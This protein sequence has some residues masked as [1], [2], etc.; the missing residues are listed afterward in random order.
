MLEIKFN[1]FLI[2]LKHKTIKQL[3]N[4]LLFSKILCDYRR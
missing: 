4:L 3:N 2:I 1:I